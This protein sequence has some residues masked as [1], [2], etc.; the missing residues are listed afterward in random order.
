MCSLGDN[1]DAWGD[2]PGIGKT[3]EMISE[4]GPHEH[5]EQM[6]ELP[7]MEVDVVRDRAP[8]ADCDDAAR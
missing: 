8:R 6:P 4:D 1:T 2:E 7:G 3:R 5:N